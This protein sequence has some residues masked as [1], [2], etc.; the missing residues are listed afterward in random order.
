M[1]TGA[2][3]IHRARFAKRNELKG[4]LSTTPRPDGVL[5]GVRRDF[6]FFKRYVCVCPTKKRCEIGNTLIVGPTR[7]GKG[8]LAT[9]QLLSWKHSVIVNDIKGEL[10]S[11]T[12]GYRAT[13]GKVF[14]I[15]PT[16]VGHCYDPLQGKHTEDEFLSAAKHLLYQ[17]DE[18]DKVFTQRSIGMLS[19]LFTAANIEG[20]APFPYVRSMMRSSLRSCAKRLNNVD[21]HLATRFLYADYKDANFENKF[22]V[23]SWETLTAWLEPL[24]AETVIRSLTRSDFT[25]EQIMRGDSPVTVYLRWKER[26]LLALS[27][28]VRLSWGSLIDELITIYDDNQGKGCKSVLLLIDEASRTAIPALADHATTVVGRGIYLWIAVQSLSQLEAAYGKEKAQ[29]LKDNME[30]HL[31]YP[32]ND[33]GTAKHI[34]EWLGHKSEYAYSTTSKEGEEVQEGLSERPIP[35]LTAQEIT[36]LSDEEIICFHRRLHPF[37]ITRMDWRRHPTLTQR[38]NI[39]A[40]ELSPL[41]QIVGIPPNPG[42]NQTTQHPAE[43]INPDMLHSNSETTIIDFFRRE[44]EA[45]RLN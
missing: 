35:L 4:L 26:D 2:V 25:P 27:P 20:I 3:D 43:Y 9:S 22:L 5:L 16:G 23:S 13:L 30:T 11:Q 44:R 42:G 17:P 14:V 34:E 18:R 21:P 33:I 39:P 31:Y 41:P 38:R 29:V 15:D 40:P 6:L 32:P 8:L 24:L 36:Q 7:S 12:A 10:F 45:D 1:G 37:K 19:R 28:L